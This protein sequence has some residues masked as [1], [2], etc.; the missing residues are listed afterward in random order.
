MSLR[1]TA[2][3]NA[4]L[5]L[6]IVTSLIPSTLVQ[7]FDPLGRCW[8]LVSPSVHQLYRFTFLGLKMNLLAFLFTN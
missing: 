5:V 2:L 1:H 7:S 3:Y 4:Y 6:S 8:L